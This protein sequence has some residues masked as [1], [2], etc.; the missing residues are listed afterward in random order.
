MS[1]AHPF[2]ML[3]RVPDDVRRDMPHMMKNVPRQEGVHPIQLRSTATT[4]A[5]SPACMVEVSSKLFAELACVCGAQVDLVGGAVDAERHGLGSLAAIEI[6]YE[7]HLNLLC[8]GSQPFH[9]E[10]VY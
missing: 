10:H 3:A 6:V 9:L 1:G 4:S 5:T 2:R 8:H 7:Q